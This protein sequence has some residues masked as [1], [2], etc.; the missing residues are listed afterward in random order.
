MIDILKNLWNY[1]RIALV[2]S[3]DS[4]GAGGADAAS[5]AAVVP[6]HCAQP[7]CCFRCFSITSQ[8]AARP[9]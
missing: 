1:T 9:R 5:G 4:Y 8:R 2:H 7:P 6:L 3:T